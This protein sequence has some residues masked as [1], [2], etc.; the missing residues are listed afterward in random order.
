M[1]GNLLAVVCHIVRQIQHKQREKDKMAKSQVCFY[2]SEINCCHLP[3]IARCLMKKF[4][5]DLRLLLMNKVTRTAELPRTMTES[6]IHNTVNC[7]VYNEKK[8][9]NLIKES[10][11][12]HLL[13]QAAA[14]ATTCCRW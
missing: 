11:F 5:R 10:E 2:K 14:A 9:D 8:K 4:I 12:C 13:L 1:G 7:S 6:S 3:A